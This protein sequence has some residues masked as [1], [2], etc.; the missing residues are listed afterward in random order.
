[1][2]RRDEAISCKITSPLQDQPGLRRQ[3]RNAIK[4]HLSALLKDRFA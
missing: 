4:N 1:M 2:D 3:L